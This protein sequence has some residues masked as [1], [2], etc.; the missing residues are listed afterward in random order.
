MPLAAAAGDLFVF[1]LFV[2]LGRADHEASLDLPELL[3]AMVPFALAWFAVAP[4]LGAYRASSLRSFRRT[5]TRLLPTWLLCGSLAVLL[6]MW[7]YD[8]PF[9]VSF[10]VVA[11]TFQAAM[12]MAWRLAFALLLR[13]RGAH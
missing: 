5:W 9:I 11:L 1:F 3:K 12:L 13:R 10:V 7:W 2:L 8:R 6:R 4:W